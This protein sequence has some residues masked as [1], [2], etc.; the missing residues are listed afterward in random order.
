V[1]DVAAFEDDLKTHRV[2]LLVYNSQASDPM[3]ERMQRL[4][5]ASHIPV[6][7]ATET[8]PLEKTIKRGLPVNSTRLNGHCRNSHESRPE[9]VNGRVDLL[10]LADA[11]VR[12]FNAFDQEIWFRDIVAR[13]GRATL[14]R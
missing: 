5:K 4:A 3:A 10:K 11:G 14:G 6:V 8:E 12:R 7:G 1:S 13:L 2:R 9:D